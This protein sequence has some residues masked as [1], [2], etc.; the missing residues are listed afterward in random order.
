LARIYVHKGELVVPSDPCLELPDDLSEEFF[1]IVFESFPYE[2]GHIARIH[3]RLSWADKEW[4]RQACGA[5]DESFQSAYAQASLAWASVVNEDNKWNP[6]NFCWCY[7]Q[8]V[9]SHLITEIALTETGIW[10]AH[11]TE[12]GLLTEEEFHYHFGLT[13]CQH[14]DGWAEHV[15]KLVA[16]IKE[17]MGG[18][19]VAREVT[20][21]TPEKDIHRTT[22]VGPKLV[23]P[24]FWYYSDGSTY[25][26]G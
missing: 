8:R 5:L 6:N 7:K 21:V 13:F 12:M 14:L 3:E 1:T 18:E 19:L 17:I 4:F 22:R 24:K 10:F 15:S 9:S 25:L 16:R 26:D 23:S 11:N 20:L 2:E